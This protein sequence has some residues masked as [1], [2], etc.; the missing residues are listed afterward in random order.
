MGG[1]F[2]G[3]RV[4]L[5]T[6]WQQLPLWLASPP[7]SPVIFKVMRLMSGIM[8]TYWSQ[9]LAFRYWSAKS[10]EGC[11][12]H[13]DQSP[14]LELISPLW[15]T[16]F[17]I[18]P[19]RACAQLVYCFSKLRWCT[20]RSSYLRFTFSYVDRGRSH[21]LHVAWVP[22]LTELRKSCKRSEPIP[23]SKKWNKTNMLKIRRNTL[24]LYQCLSIR[25]SS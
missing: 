10:D 20:I 22:W 7:L 1:W 13:R 18:T 24:S 23:L 6:Q 9:Y 11:S 21:I 2:P 3:P 16:N 8:E 25:P 15:T 19:Q 17:P 4:P 12:E 14:S 5:S